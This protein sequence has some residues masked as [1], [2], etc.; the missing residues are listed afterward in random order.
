MSLLKIE[1]PQKN[2]SAQNINEFPVLGIDLGTTNSLVGIVV[3]DEVRFFKDEKGRQLH[4][5][6][7]AFDE[8]GNVL[9]V[10]N[11][12]YEGNFVHKIESIKR[13]M[14]SASREIFIGSKKY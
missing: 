12:A 3:N 8:T 11:E 4:K 10:G 2:I 1:E 6:V 13:L 5:S 7:V 9:A 14:G